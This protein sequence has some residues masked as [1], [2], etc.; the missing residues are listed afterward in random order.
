MRSE[1]KQCHKLFVYTVASLKLASKYFLNIIITIIAKKYNN[2]KHIFSI[3]WLVYLIIYIFYYCKNVVVVVLITII[4]K[5]IIV[6]AI[7]YNINN[8]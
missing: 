2:N 3:Q 4:K 6:T 1:V 8:K 7:K 5:L